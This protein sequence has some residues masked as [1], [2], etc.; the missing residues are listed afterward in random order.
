MQRPGDTFYNVLRLSVIFKLL[1]FQQKLKNGIIILL[2][3]WAK[4]YA[5]G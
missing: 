4:D 5:T 3:T 1:C 2:T